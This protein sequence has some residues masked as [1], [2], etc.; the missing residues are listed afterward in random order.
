MMY[1]MDGH[2]LVPLIF[3]F[4]ESY[5][6]LFWICRRTSGT[7]AELP[8][9]WSI[10]IHNWRAEQA[11][12]SSG[13]LIFF[14]EQTWLSQRN[15]SRSSPSCGPSS[16]WTKKGRLLFLQVPAEAQEWK[17]SC[18]FLIKPEADWLCL[19]CW[20]GD[21]VSCKSVFLASAACCRLGQW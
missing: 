2:I 4:L 21:I 7:S 19:D 12:T 3:P 1:V 14:K 18:C 10:L 17:F 9:I 8:Y 5:K 16:R 11:A 20:Y 13:S 15:L 6:F